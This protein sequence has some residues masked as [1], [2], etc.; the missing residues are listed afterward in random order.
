MIFEY[1]LHVEKHIYDVL[2][3]SVMVSFNS[4]LRTVKY[5]KRPLIIGTCQQQE[6]EDPTVDIQTLY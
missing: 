6:Q 3:F 4:M 1:F 5:D 2:S